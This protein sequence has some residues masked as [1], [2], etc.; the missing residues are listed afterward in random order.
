MSQENLE[1]VRAML[2]TWNLPGDEWLAFFD[3]AVEF[4]DVQVVTGMRDRGSGIDDLRKAAD[5]WVEI[6]REWRIEVRDLV[7]LGGDHV[8]AELQFSAIGA[9][10]G[11]PVSGDQVDIYRLR[12]GKVV[13]YRAGY[14]SKKEALKAVGLRE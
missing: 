3:P 7:D 13:E 2:E 9:E 10:S 12:D 8:L 14:R 6:F 1:L 11:V 5:Q 4:S